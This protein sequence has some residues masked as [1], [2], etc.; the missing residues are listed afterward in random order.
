M[1]LSRPRVLCALMAGVVTLAVGLVS[2]PSAEA[3]PAGGA[4]GPTATARARVA[5]D[6]LMSSYEPVKAWFPSSWW[7][8]AVALQTIGDYMQRTGDR[9]YLQQLDNTFEKDKG[10]FPAGYLSGDPLLGN[11]TSRAI[12]DSEWWALTWIQAYDLT[13]QRKYLDMAVTIAEYVEDYWDDTCGGGVWWD[14]ERTYKN[15]VTNGL[16]I[17]LTAEL[18]NRIP[19]DRHWL[20]RAQQGWNW[21]TGSGMINS[22]GLVNDGL[23][24]GTCQ[25]NNDTVWTYNQG[26]AIGAGL[27][28]WRATR[29]PELLTTVRRLADSATG[30]GGLVSNGVLTESCDVPGK[31][32]D[33]NQKQ[34]KGIFMRYW[35]DLADTT[36]DPRYAAFLA[37]QAA[38]VWDSDRDAAGRLGQRWSGA[39]SSDNP[40]VFDWRTQASALSALIAAVPA[41][42]PVQSLSAAMTPAQPV[43]MPASGSA[44]H[45]ALV[46]GLQA[47]APAGQ[48]IKTEVRATGPT[49][50]TVTPSRA[51]V[52]LRPTGNAVPARANVEL[53]VAIPAGTPDGRYPVTVTATSGPLLSFSTQ[54]EILVAH[55]A[56]FDTGTAAESPWLW[57]AGGSQSNGIQN[58]FADGHAYFVYR[59]PFPSDTTS[60]SATLTLDNEYVVEVS[61][62]GQQWTTV[63]RET[64]HVHD[65]QN[66]ATQT[67]DLTPHLGPNKAAYIRI[68]DSFPDEGWGGRV[69]HVTA[70]YTG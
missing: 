50:W 7:N 26:L 58:R 27:E 34:F 41:L 66:K 13:K 28:L 15:A 21:F 55:T 59:F 19:G 65:G 4:D 14:A 53:D 8:S 5:A 42:P 62:D 61:G 2:L 70:T 45:V 6:V 20:G 35:M 56:D 40:N 17:R 63:A 31:V 30:A 57:D 67:F 25:S 46:A 29:N 16:W 36:R 12:D 24:T 18:H 33:D 1:V 38:N 48:V 39:T 11:F 51:T 52:T 23:N 49:G 68:S 3:D 37:K 69:Y 54:A 43:V 60:A 64:E 9:R 44:T 47:R 10:V 22:G 32:C